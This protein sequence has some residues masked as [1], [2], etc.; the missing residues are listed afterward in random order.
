MSTQKKIEEAL[1]RS[2]CGGWDR[3]FLES[4]LDQIS[5]GR[6]LSAKQKQTLGK[7][8]ARNT[9]D[10]QAK[11]ANWESVYETEYKTTATILAFYH[12]RQPYYK[13]MAQDILLDRIPER[14]KFLRMYDNKYSKK[15]LG[16]HR[17]PPK[18]DL[19][20]YLQPRASC[21]AHKNIEIE[22]HDLMWSTK[23]ALVDSFKKKGGF[24]VK[25]C[26]EIHSAAKGAKRYKLLPIGATMP[27]VVEE[28]F[29]K[30]G[31]VHN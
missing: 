31:K 27:L 19:G 14:N 7:V 15:V 29:L 1:N 2:V 23:T 22:G 24:V 25:V 13:P 8:L 12:V 4:I 5:K 16:Q 6:D 18:Y 28:R 20:D 21:D 9:S 10:A 3:G 11:H 26:H 17:A 30:R